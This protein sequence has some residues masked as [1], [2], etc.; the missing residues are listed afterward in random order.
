[1]PKK[2][3]ES[4]WQEL[5]AKAYYPCQREVVT[6]IG[7]IDILTPTILIEVKR[8]K[9]WKDAI[10]QLLGYSAYYPQHIKYLYLFGELDIRQLGE[11]KQLC[12]IHKIILTISFFEEVEKNIII[13]GLC[14]AKSIITD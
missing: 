2:Q 4:E 6:P 7:R 14:I 5:L 8:S 9:K 10:G 1:M 13:R 11:V 12:D 3:L